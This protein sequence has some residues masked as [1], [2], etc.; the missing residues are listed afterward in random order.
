M[1]EKLASDLYQELGR[2][3]FQV[4]STRLSIQ[5]IRDPF[6]E[7]KYPQVIG[8]FVDDRG[9]TEC[10]RI[11]S[12]F[13]EGYQ[14]FQHAKTFDQGRP[15]PFIEY[16][17]Q[18]HRPP[19]T[20]LTPTGISVPL[21]GFMSLLA[22]ARILADVDVL[23]GSGGNAGF[24]WVKNEAGDI[25]GMRIVKIDP[26]FAFTFTGSSNWVTCTQERSFNPEY[27]L[28]D[29][30]DL[31]TASLNLSVN[32]HWDKLTPAQ[33][34]EFLAALLNCTRYLESKEVFSFLFHREGRFN[35]GEME[36]FPEMFINELQ[37]GL[38][39]WLEN[40]LAIYGDDLREFKR[41]HPE[42]LIRMHYIDKWGEIELPLAKE[43]F[44]IRELF[45]NL[46][47]V[48]EEPNPIP[49]PAE[50]NLFEEPYLKGTSTPILLEELFHPIEGKVAGK[51]LLLGRAGIGKSTICQKISHDWS[52][53]LLWNELFD[54]V[55]WIPLR[56]L[57]DKKLSFNDIDLFL[58][59]VISHL[60]LKDAVDLPTVLDLVKTHRQK[61]LILLD[62]LDEASPELQE[63]VKKMLQEKD[64]TIILTSR[65][66]TADAL[67]APIDLRVEN[68]GFS[69]TH[70]EA[71]AE[72]FFSRGTLENLRFDIP[73]F[74]KTV[75]AHQNLFNLAHIPL[76]LQM[77]CSLWQQRGNSFASDLPALYGQMV[78]QLL[79]W[80]SKRLNAS[81]IQES[82][83]CLGELAQQGLLTH[84]LML[85]REMVLSALKTT[86][87]SLEDL[88]ATGLLKECAEGQFYSFLHLSFQEYLIARAVAIQSPVEQKAFIL[89][90][91]DNAAYQ[92]TLS[93]L[94][95]LLYRESPTK[96]QFFFEALYQTPL[97]Q[98][99]EARIK[100]GLRLLN[101]YPNYPGTIPALDHVLAQNPKTL[102][103]L[104]E[105]ASF[106][107]QTHT[108]E[109]LYTHNPSRFHQKDQK[110]FTPFM[111]V[112]F[113]GNTKL[114]KW[115]YGK[116][117][118]L[119][120]GEMNENSREPLHEEGWTPLHMAAQ[121]GHL[122]LAEWLDEKDPSLIQTFK[123]NG[124]TPLHS[125]AQ[126]NRL[127]IADWLCLKNRD[128]LHTFRNDGWTPLHAAISKGHITMAEQLYLQNRALLIEPTKS[129]WYILD[130]FGM[131]YKEKL[132]ET[133]KTNPSQNSSQPFSSDGWTPLHA[134]TYNGH[135]EAV[136]WVCFT[137]PALINKANRAGDTP[138]ALAIKSGHLEIVKWFLCQDSIPL[139]TLSNAFSAYHAACEGHLELMKYLYTNASFYFAKQIQQ[140]GWSALGAAENSGHQE[141][142]EWLHSISEDFVRGE[143]YESPQNNYSGFDMPFSS[144]SSP[145][146]CTGPDC[147]TP[148]VPSSSNF[149]FSIT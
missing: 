132:L 140:D 107:T 144:S 121:E 46:R 2:K 54:V 146:V 141:M 75:R 123:K 23:G 45:T 71:Y 3:L 20:I 5:P 56:L 65:P 25:L 148:S 89:K 73:S 108:I 47:I 60:I 94:C 95:G 98:N 66:A 147:P 76:Q 50:P 134:A 40:Q 96:M 32:I 133:A 142:I 51:I 101:E 128:L 6:M 137:N 103:A 139:E 4:P 8:G 62:G 14:N 55:Y 127:E 90:Y 10:L 85:P 39:K 27:F 68:I 28:S 74:L 34:T 105:D 79:R 26:G 109:Y 48:K 88:L 15:I 19:E 115:L 78:D 72:R 57:N 31:Q 7:E 102:D 33:R 149:S 17:E 82:L 36:Q 44:P 116:D 24:V 92:M 11:M 145:S 129:N 69:D 43:T 80:N 13:I 12:C 42:Q 93:F 126:E 59:E 122:E 110:G 124:W 135:L 18:Y 1:K 84:Q 106:Y 35:R 63:T 21:N 70:I 52:S 130:L 83:L 99:V 61:S 77:L 41:L 131:S 37:E 86:S 58:A 120:L 29:L 138:P 117:E 91:R 64:L 125:A 9:I 16:I 118:R 136:Q 114:A 113:A 53:G 22:V 49:T 97:D 81:K 143:V 38:K 111:W 30:R 87:L 119:L 67:K 112:C 104:F 100:L